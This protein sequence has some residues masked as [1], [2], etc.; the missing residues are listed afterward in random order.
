M[1]RRHRRSRSARRRRAG[2]RPGRHAQRRARGSPRRN[3]P[4][5]PGPL[6]GRSVVSEAQSSALIMVRA[7]R[8]LPRASEV[9]RRP[10]GRAFCPAIPG[11]C[12]ALVDIDESAARGGWVRPARREGGRSRS[13]PRR[14]TGPRRAWT[15]ANQSRSLVH[16][17]VAAIPGGA[18]WRWSSRCSWCRSS[19][20]TRTALTAAGSDSFTARTAEWLRGNHLGAL[21]SWAEHINYSLHPPR[22]GGTPSA[23]AGLA[24]SAVPASRPRR[25][26]PDDACARHG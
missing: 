11:S 12:S 19:G 26:G 16:A 4:A 6:N 21:V 5:P 23:R 20:P 17:V 13:R 25:S 1:T 24:V 7:R 22:K 10:R 15:R 9:W 18:G 3:P 2:R 14:A 8:S